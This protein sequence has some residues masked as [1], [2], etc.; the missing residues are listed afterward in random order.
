MAPRTRSARSAN[1]SRH[2]SKHISYKEDDSTSGLEDED[3]ENTFAPSEGCRPSSPPKRRSRPSRI[4]AKEKNSTTSMNKRKARR[5]RA[6]IRSVPTRKARRL[7][8][9]VS[10]HANYHRT[11]NLREIIPCWQNLPYHVLASIFHHLTYQRLTEG[12]FSVPDAS[13]LVEIALLCKSFVEPALSALYYWPPLY[14]L[15]RAQGLIEL[16]GSQTSNSWLN[17]SGKVKCL[18]FLAYTDF[19]K[20][21]FDFGALIALTPQLQSVRIQG[22]TSSVDLR[23]IFRALEDNLIS[24]REWT[25]FAPQ[26]GSRLEAPLKNIILTSSFQ[27]LENVSLV[28]DSRFEPGPEDLAAAINALPRLKHLCLQRWHTLDHTILSLL[29]TDLQSLQL[30][31]CDSVTSKALTDYLAARGQKLRSLVLEHNCLQDLSFLV[32]LARSCP[33]LQELKANFIFGFR[34]NGLGSEP[35]AIL[36]PDEIPTWPSSLQHLELLH[37]RRWTLI[38]ADLFF[39]S[40]VDSA[41]SLPNLRHIHIV[42]SLGESGWKS[43]VRFREKW[44]GRFMHVFLRLPE[45]PNPHLHSLGAFQAFQHDR[46]KSSAKHLNNGPNPTN[47]E[48]NPIS[49]HQGSSKV[50][51][52]AIQPGRSDTNKLLNEDKNPELHGIRRSNRLKVDAG[53]SEMSPPRPSPPVRRRR[54]RRRRTKGSDAD[55]SS[56]DSALEDEVEE[57]PVGE[58]SETYESFHVQGMCDVVHLQ[59]DNLRPFDELLRESDFLNEE[60][61]GDEDWNGSDDSN[62]D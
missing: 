13:W 30:K 21:T 44:T 28:D 11:T 56:E 16:L 40:L 9:P 33:Q 24:L 14:P 61:S 10:D 36:N 18:D 17:Y 7:N 22:R 60:A 59:F 8:E 34:Q 43:R 29:T 26:T 53:Y 6:N 3:S 19:K 41:A 62:A 42:A 4:S 54:R 48:L 32:S 5:S 57:E 46:E 37:L 31:L 45:P 12:W 35:P 39:S 51:H 55:S 38:S 23:P 27:T 1:S 52:V 49:P 50:S 2:T 47:S 58:V 25:W 20:S 15:T